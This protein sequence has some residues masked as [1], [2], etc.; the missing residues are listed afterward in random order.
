MF[1]AGAPPGF[2]WGST[3]SGTWREG[4]PNHGEHPRPCGSSRVARDGKQ[5][6]GAE[7]EFQRAAWRRS[8]ARDWHSVVF[9]S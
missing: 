9:N 5:R 1:C 8:E 6:S 7:V 4:V 3:W 2:S